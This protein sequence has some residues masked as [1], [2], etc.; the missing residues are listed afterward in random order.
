[1][2]RR[3]FLALVVATSV[4]LTACSGSSSSPSPTPTPS[5]TPAPALT[6]PK[7]IL[8]NAAGSLRGVT[9]VHVK[10]ALSGTIDLGG[11]MGSGD[12]DPSAAAKFDLAGSTLEGDIDV[13]GS[14]A[15][16]AIEA[17]NLL[18][19]KADVI[20]DSGTIYLKSS[21]TGDKYRK[22]PAS[23]LTS[24]LPLPSGA[25]GA[26]PDPNASA[27]IDSLKAQ[28]AGL[29]APVKLADETINGVDSNHIQQVVSN[30]DIPQASGLPSG[31]VTLDI[32]TSKADGRPT[33]LVVSADAGTQGN[34]AVTID[35]TGY[36]AGVSI[37]PPPADQVS[38]QP[39]SF[40]GLTP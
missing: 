7:D 4:L 5:P 1:M 17:P 20:V 2:P 33:R 18:S 6:D 16:F 35:L 13:A 3:L 26:S 37:A 34:L 11:L 22:L 8:T 24:N 9:S 10:A 32:W 39:F 19:L 27:M 31:K 12:A 23:T 40:P 36:N 21:L 15:R 29:P 25:A 14:K 30:T 38:D 28:L